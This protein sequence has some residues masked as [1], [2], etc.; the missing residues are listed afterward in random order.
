[1]VDGAEDNR[2]IDG[3]SS[4]GKAAAVAAVLLS[5]SPAMAMPVEAAPAVAM[6]TMTAV[7]AVLALALVAS[8]GLHIAVRTG[9]VGRER[10]VAVRRRL[11]VGFG[12]GFL[13]AAVTPYVALNFSAAALVPFIGAAGL[14]VAAWVWG[15]SR[16]YGLESGSNSA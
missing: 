10:Q 11:R 3:G 5:P 13:L 7:T 14:V 15:A 6:Y 16:R 12:V 2:S 8:V 4:V 9:V 1:M